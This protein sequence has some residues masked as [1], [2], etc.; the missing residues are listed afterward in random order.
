MRRAD[1]DSDNARAPIAP[2]TT[3]LT[4]ASPHGQTLARL[5]A[6]RAAHH[7]ARL[8]CAHRRVPAP[9]SRVARTRAIEAS[10]KAGPL[11]ER[12]AIALVRSGALAQAESVLR[13]LRKLPELPRVVRVRERIVGELL[14]VVVF[15]VP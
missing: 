12:T 4:A 8:A 9:L 2:A 10:G 3:R 14:L 11:S 5:R 15:V 13:E 1:G 7:A 6:C